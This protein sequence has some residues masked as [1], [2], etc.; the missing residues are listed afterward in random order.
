MNNIV[1]QYLSVKY[2]DKVQ[3]YTDDSKDPDTALSYFV[4]PANE[5]R[6]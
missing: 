4:S 3:V 1:Q 5:R 6:F 2:K